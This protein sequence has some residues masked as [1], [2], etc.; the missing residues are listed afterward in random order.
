MKLQRS[1]TLASLLV[2]GACAV[3]PATGRRELALVSESAEIQMGRDADPQIVAQ[4]GLVEDEGLQRYVSDLGRE[5]AEVSERPDLPWTFR[6][7]DDP[8]VNAFALPG[9]F[10]YV[11]RG[12][13]LNFDS[14]AELAG[15]LGHEI[16]HVTARHSVSQMSRQ[17]LQQIGL[18]VGMVLSENVRQYGGLLSAGMQLLNLSYSRDDETQ[19]DEL[20]LRYISSLGYDP[21]AMIGVFDMLAQAGG[22]QDGEGR[23]P[24]WQ[25]THP[26]P[27]NRAENIRSFIAEEG[28]PTSGTVERDTYLAQLDGVVYGENPRHGY[29]KDARF[30]HPE[31]AFELTFPSGWRT[32]NQRSVVAAIEPS[33]EAI[34]TL[35][36]AEEESDP[37]AALRTF[38]AQEGI[39]G[40]TV[41]EDTSGGVQRA[42][43]DF[44]AATEEGPV[45]GEVAF[46]RHGSLTYRMLGYAPN[47]AAWPRHAGSVSSTV[48]SFGALTDRAILG[49][50]PWTVEIRTLRSATS[51]NTY[52][53]NNPSPVGIEQLARLNRVTPQDVLDGGTSIKW[54]VGEPLP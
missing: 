40:G 11:T 51:L 34:V 19:S 35:E 45:R 38:L 32:I 13:L 5:L 41:R 31:L 47:A 53:A 8:T 48:T 20:G 22:G 39:M 15:V 4:L 33:Q 26:Y 36:V 29:F 49:A 43:A 44:E 16:G 50:Q 12:I 14:E 7:V 10:I 25:L 3:N 54:V 30:V 18:G 6:V 37:G 28:L 52:A 42:R 2:F 9:G 21:T 46:M 27:E 23:I 24:E 1:L 17:Q